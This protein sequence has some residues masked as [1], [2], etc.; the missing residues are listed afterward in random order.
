MQALANRFEAP[1]ALPT[2]WIKK[3]FQ[4]LTAMYGSKLPQMW[5]GVPEEAVHAVWAEDLAGFSGDEIAVGLQACKQRD[6]PPTLP[7]FL[8]LCRPWMAPEVAYHEAVHGM[9]AR[10]RGQMGSWS[11][12]AVYWAAIGVSTVDLLGSTY[13]QIKARWE[14]TLS[15]EIAKGE[16]HPIPEPR[17]ALPAPG[18]TLATKEEAA[19]ALKRMGADKALDQTGR[20]T[21]RWIAALDK[22]VAKG[23]RL[24]PTVAAML[25]KAK[26]EQS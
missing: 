25:T 5:G 11:H 4:R 17:T 15:E 26:G 24:S 10:Q 9:T 6:W 21:R 12:P 23:E 8:K 3:L 19:A 13:G 1:Q 14:K 20:D 16:W 18:Q 22:R 7:E 2:P